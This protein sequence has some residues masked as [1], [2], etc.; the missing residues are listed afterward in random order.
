MLSDRISSYRPS[1]FFAVRGGVHGDWTGLSES[2]LFEGRDLAVTTDYR[3]VLHE[4]LRAHLGAEPPA[5]TFPGFEPT[6]VGVI[7]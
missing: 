6:A 1:Q 5:K 4:V 3:D 2:A 7:A